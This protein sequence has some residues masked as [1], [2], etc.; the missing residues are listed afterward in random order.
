MANQYKRPSPI[1]GFIF[2][3]KALLA[4]LLSLSSL[5]FLGLQVYQKREAELVNV[6]Q[7]AKPTKI[8]ADRCAYTGGF[9][10]LEPPVSQTMLGFHLQWEEEA[11]RPVPMRERL[12]RTP[13]IMYNLL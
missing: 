12:G 2:W 11:E 13:A 3:C 1:W 7:R 5:S 10:R 9:S 4:I 6:A 8:T